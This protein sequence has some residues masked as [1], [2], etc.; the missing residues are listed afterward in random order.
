VQGRSFA[1]VLDDAL[2]DHLEAP[3]PE[4]SAGTVIPQL[5]NPFL[6]L[7]LPPGAGQ[8]IAFV[9][10]ERSGKPHR[11]ETAPVHF[12]LQRPS[13]VLSLAQ[14]SALG[15]LLALGARLTPEFTSRELR[16][17]YRLIARRTHHD[18]HPDRTTVERAA[19]S[20]QFADAAESYGRLLAIVEPRH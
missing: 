14:Q 11:F 7:K 12:N 3:R 5:P 4:P 9:S 17:E 20:R 1:D 16:R 18:C 2:V 15:T 13:R 19:L 8:P 10:S 6:F